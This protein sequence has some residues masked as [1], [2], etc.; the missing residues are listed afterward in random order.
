VDDTWGRTGKNCEVAEDLDITGFFDLFL[1]C[2]A[3]CDEISP[4]NIRSKN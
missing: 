1:A 3:R 4:L 2:V